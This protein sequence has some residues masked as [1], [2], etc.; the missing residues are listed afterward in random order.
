MNKE[1]Y[2]QWLDKIQHEKKISTG[3]SAI[4]SIFGGGIRPQVYTIGAQSSLGKTS[5]M[6]QIACE[7]AKNG[8]HVVYF[9]LEQSEG[10]LINKTISRLSGE[11]SV[12]DIID[13]EA[14]DIDA[15]ASKYFT[16]IAPNFD[17]ISDFGNTQPD[18]V[19]ILA[20]MTHSKKEHE[21]VVFFIDYMQLIGSSELDIRDTDKQRV[22]KIMYKLKNFVKEHE[23]PIF[24]ISSFNRSSYDKQDVSFSDFKESSNIE[25][26][27][28][29]VMALQFRNRHEPDFDPKLARKEDVRKLELTILKNRMGSNGEVLLDFEPRINNFTDPFEIKIK[30]Q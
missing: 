14:W 27:S 1:A 18:I 6:L 17:I 4:D 8:T 28:D 21:S 5:L 15:H 20:M 26:Q 25:F 29:I 13:G 16:E 12:Q 23:V 10:D 19:R 3:F 30:K 11:Y 22:D 7:I 9:A 24:I 2:L